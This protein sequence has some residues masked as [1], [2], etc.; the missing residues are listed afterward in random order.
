MF[1]WELDFDSHFHHN[2]F[3]LLSQ[4]EFWAKYANFM[5]IAR[6]QEYATLQVEFI[7][8]TFTWEGEW[9]QKCTC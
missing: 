4:A 8:A 9:G 3:L 6:K 2:F 7:Q 1:S 5:D